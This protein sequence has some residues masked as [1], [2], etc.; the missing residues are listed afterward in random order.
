MSR[1]IKIIVTVPESDSNKL[2]NAL[3]KAGAGSIGNY[4]YGSFTT[5]GV[6]RGKALNGANPTK[7]EI[8]EIEETNEEKIETFCKKEIL[9]Q[10]ITTI[11]EN[12]PYEEPIITYYPVEIVE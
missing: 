2:R 8:G 5:K 12:H 7:G 6:G 1:Y 9:E 4:S 11:K 3:G 10:V